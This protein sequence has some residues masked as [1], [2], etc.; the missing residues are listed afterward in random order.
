ML[1]EVST[2]ESTVTVMAAESPHNVND[3]RSQSAE[4]L[5]TL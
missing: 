3:H 1:K 2:H 4:D 5:L